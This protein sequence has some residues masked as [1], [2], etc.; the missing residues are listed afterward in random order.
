MFNAIFEALYLLKL[1][2][3]FKPQFQIGGW[4]AKDLL[5]WESA[6][7]HSIKLGFE[8]QVAKKFLNGT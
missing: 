5:L 3:N 4:S 2:Q 6:I 8:G 7:Y 1:G